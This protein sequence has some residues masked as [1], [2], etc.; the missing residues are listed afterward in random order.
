MTAASTRTHKRRVARGSG[1][2]KRRRAA[3]NAQSQN[4]GSSSSSGGGPNDLDKQPPGLAGNVAPVPVPSLAGPPSKVPGT[5]IQTGSDFGV[6]ARN[7][8]IIVDKTLICKAFVKRGRAPV[9][10]CLPKRYGKTF[11]LSISEKLLNVANSSDAHP[12]DGQIGIPDGEHRRAWD[13]MLLTTIFDSN[14]CIAWANECKSMLDKLYVGYLCDIYQQFNYALQRLS[15]ASRTMYEATSANL[16][17][18]FTLLKMVLPL[19]QSD[20]DDYSGGDEIGSMS[21][22]EGQSGN[23]WFGWRVVFPSCGPH[24]PK[25]LCVT[26]E[27]KQIRRGSSQIT[28]HPLRMAQEGLEQIIDRRYATEINHAHRRLDADVEIGMR[29]VAIRQR[30]WRPASEEERRAHAQ[31]RQNVRYADTDG[32][33]TIEEWDQQHIDSDNAGWVDEHGWITERISDEFRVTESVVHML[34]CAHGEQEAELPP[35]STSATPAADDMSARF[36]AER[37]GHLILVQWW[38]DNF[39]QA[40][41]R[42]YRQ[43]NRPLNQTFTEE[44]IHRCRITFRS[45]VASAYDR[46]LVRN[47]LQIDRELRSIIP[48][49]TRRSTMR[50]NKR[51]GFQ[52]ATADGVPSFPRTF[53][54]RGL[55]FKEFCSASLQFQMTLYPHTQK[56]MRKHGNLVTTSILQLQLAAEG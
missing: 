43:Y 40:L 5:R 44:F 17:R 12:M 26:F 19:P 31:P 35:P 25:P 53:A 1:Q 6:M 20:M 49:A 2:N 27:F 56:R 51:S 13:D 55:E 54:N 24:R 22:N 42:D 45:A 10:V 8:D 41:E 18:T 11:N 38:I 23:G 21:I 16:F 9:C 3:Q 33:T 52:T 15:H 50:R 32:G 4:T 28:G 7:T 37:H 47:K 30:M 46:S 48:P 29:A 36:V 39:K 34:T 14:S